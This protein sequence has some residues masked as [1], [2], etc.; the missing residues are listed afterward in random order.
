MVKTSSNERILGVQVSSRLN[1][2][3]EQVD[4]VIREAAKVM[5]GLKMGGHHL[6][7]KQR[8]AT[9]R[10]CYLSKL[11]YSIDL[12]GHGL[13]KNQTESLQVAQNEIL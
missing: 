10:S 9:V 7:F 1:S 13:S 12:W 11:F 4:K 2:W 8:L 3:K 6:N 5:G